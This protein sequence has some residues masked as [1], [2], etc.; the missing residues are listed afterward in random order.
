MV[1]FLTSEV[2]SDSLSLPEV[3][4]AKRTPTSPKAIY[5]DDFDKLPQEVIYKFNQVDRMITH[6]NQASSDER[7]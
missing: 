1:E 5:S 6:A 4:N 7:L 3:I 2:Q